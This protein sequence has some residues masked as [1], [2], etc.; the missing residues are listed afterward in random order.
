MLYMYDIGVC[1][2]THSSLYDLSKP[3]PYVSSHSYPP[4]GTVL[5]CRRRTT[6]VVQDLQVTA[7]PASRPQS[8]LSYLTSRTDKTALLFTLHHPLTPPGPSSSDVSPCPAYPYLPD[9]LLASL[10]H[11]TAQ[12]HTSIYLFISRYGLMPI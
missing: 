3:V 1:K 9:R 6:P 7:P 4:L 5:A 12:I 8:G 11:L 10:S 2:L